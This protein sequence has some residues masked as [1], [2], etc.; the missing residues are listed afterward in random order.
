MSVT[1]LGLPAGIKACLFDL[2]G[3][4]V[5]TSELHEQAWKRMFDD[6][7]S[8]RAAGGRLDEFT[9]HD[10]DRYV[11]GRLRREGTRGFLA[12]RGIELPEGEPADAPGTET[13]WGLSNRKNEIL[14]GLIRSGGVKTYDGSVRYLHS[15]RQAGL[16]CV[17]VSSS[18][19]AG[20]VIDSVGLGRL[21]DGCIDGNVAGR[22]GLAGKPAPDTFLA[23]AELVGA[24]PPQATVFEDALAGVAAGRAGGFGFVVG[25]D[26][27]GQN[28]ELREAGADVVVTDLAELIR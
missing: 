23:G 27:V 5:Q 13:I 3:V 24:A 26:R 9:E 18:A 22:R 20:E 14:L 1:E 12:S 8:E 7:L 6:F 16:S 21:F 15:V 2:D 28:D 17:V 4:L 25:V 10:Y 19:N 11:N